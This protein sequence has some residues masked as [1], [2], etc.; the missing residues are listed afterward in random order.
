MFSCINNNSW[1]FHISIF[2]E[3]EYKER[4]AYEKQR[5]EYEKQQRTAA[6]YKVGLFFLEDGG[7]LWVLTSRYEDPVLAIKNRIRGSVPQT[8]V[9][10]FFVFILLVLDV[11]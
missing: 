5:A 9:N 1:K 6:E 7:A 11:P 2:Q 4:E 3:R 10:F 8:K